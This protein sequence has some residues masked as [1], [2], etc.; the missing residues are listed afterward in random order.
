MPKLAQTATRSL[1]E[2]QFYA[3]NRAVGRFGIRS[4]RPQIMPAPHWHGH[5]EFN[6]LAEASMVYDVDGAR[7]EVPPDRL[8][9]FW[10]GV[11]HQLTEISPPGTVPPRLTNIYLPLDGFLL[12]PHIATLQ[13]ALLNGGFAILPEEICGPEQLSRW[14]RDYRTN[15]VER[16]EVLKMEINATLRRA[17]LGGID[18]PTGASG[19]ET[20]RSQGSTHVHH[21]VAMIRFIVENLAQPMTNGDIAAASGLHE[22]YA[23]T[24]FSRVMRLPPKQFLIRMRLLRARALLIESGI[25]VTAVVTASGFSSTS[26][27]YTHFRT[28]YG[29]SPQ[30]MRERYTAM[31]VR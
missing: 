4:F 13:V 23:T 12:M 16:V 7:V 27:F 11:P 25:P 28:A 10:A 6:F 30:V 18:W 1:H 2:R 9:V 24:L 26:Q 5:V 20:E 14:Y 29:M 19:M 22:N 21:V 31:T 8:T 15:D 17:L 3:L